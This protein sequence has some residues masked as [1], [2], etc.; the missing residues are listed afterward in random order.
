ME[1]A[2]RPSF[3]PAAAGGLLLGVLVGVIGVGALI[4][5][6]AGSVGYGILIGAVVG[7]PAAVFAVYRRYRGAI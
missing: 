2:A 1:P 6:A 4:G 5:W 3:Q 7:L